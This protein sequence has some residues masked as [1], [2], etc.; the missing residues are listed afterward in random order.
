MRWRWKLP[1]DRKVVTRSPARPGERGGRGLFTRC[2]SAFRS[3]VERQAAGNAGGVEA[4]R[5][6]RHAQRGVGA[7]LVLAANADEIIAIGVVKAGGDGH[8]QHLRSVDIHPLIAAAREQL[9]AIANLHAD[10]AGDAI[11]AVDGVRAEVVIALSTQDQGRAD[12][13]VD[14]GIDAIDRAVISTDR[15]AAK[16]MIA[17]L[18]ADIDLR[19]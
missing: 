17:D 8:V 13:N 19:Q 6:D 16:V 15:V 14:T 4:Q 1:N 12:G 18:A 2:G 9:A 5:I 7:D 3:E 11:F 10:L